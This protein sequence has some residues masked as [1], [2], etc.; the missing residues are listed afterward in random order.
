MLALG[1]VFC[2]HALISI[3]MYL[4]SNDTAPSSK[5]A[6]QTPIKMNACGDYFLIVDNYSCFYMERSYDSAIGSLSKKYSADKYSYSIRNS[7]I[8]LVANYRDLVSKWASREQNALKDLVNAPVLY[9]IQRGRETGL[10]DGDE[11]EKDMPPI[12][13]SFSGKT[14]EDFAKAIKER[15]IDYLN[16]QPKVTPNKYSVVLRSNEDLDQMAFDIEKVKREIKIVTDVLVDAPQQAVALPLI[17]KDL[18]V[19]KNENRYLR[20][21]VGDLENTI[22]SLIMGMLTI[23][24][25]LLGFAIAHIHS[26]KSKS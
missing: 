16:W 23:V 9:N 1:V 21:T 7:K 4:Y 8:K 2:I 20:D 18:E 24:V 13:S 22:T 10:I 3:G 17:K 11:E 26:L 12:V 6:I 14:E 15:Q 25:S 5:L 19:L